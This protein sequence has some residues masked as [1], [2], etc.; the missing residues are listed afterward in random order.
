MATEN[1][2]MDEVKM[3]GNRQEFH[4]EIRELSMI[5]GKHVKEEGKDNDLLDLIAAD[6]KFHMTREELNKYIDPHLFVGAA[7]HQVER[8]LR[9]VVQPVLDANQ[10]QL[11]VTA[12]IN[13]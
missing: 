12:Q 7:P 13:V 4:E 3:G 10:D 8:Y 2:M 11:G 9:E 5:A 1:I 6:P